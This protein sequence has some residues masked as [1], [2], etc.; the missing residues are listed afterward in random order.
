MLYC[1][2]FFCLAPYFGFE[3]D[4][5]SFF[6]IKINTPRAVLVSCRASFQS[7]SPPPPANAVWR[8]QIAPLIHK[9]AGNLRAVRESKLAA[10]AVR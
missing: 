8:P 3:V 9:R 4:A 7:A 5:G 6:Y 2:Y 1:G 10:S